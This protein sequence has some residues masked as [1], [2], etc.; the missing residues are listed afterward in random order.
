[1]DVQKQYNTVLSGMGTDITKNLLDLNEKEQVENIKSKA[2]ELKNKP[3]DV[4]G[5]ANLTGAAYIASLPAQKQPLIKQLVSGQMA[6]GQLQRVLSGKDGQQLMAEVALADPDFDAAKIGAYIDASKKFASD[7]IAN[8]LNSANTSL[9]HLKALYQDNLLPGAFVGGKNYAQ[10]QADLN[11][12]SMELARFLTGG[13]APGKED[14][15]NARASLDP[16]AFRSFDVTGAK[17]KAVETQTKRI[18]EKMD[19]YEEQW[20]DAVPSPHWKRPMPG[21]LGSHP[22]A[23]AAADFIENGGKA[24]VAAAPSFSVALPD[25]SVAHFPSQQQMDQF[26]KQAGIQ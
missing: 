9:V 13:T 4:E 22:D 5:D 11:D 25:G 12:A 21:G 15:A 7:R 26:K 19:Q 17:Q 2:T 16:S 10:R 20:S 8:Q 18:K 1:L 6:T 23:K 3:M 14:I 24:P